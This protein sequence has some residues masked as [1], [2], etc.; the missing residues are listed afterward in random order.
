MSVHFF[1]LIVKVMH[2]HCRKKNLNLEKHIEE[3]KKLLIVLLP[4]ITITDIS[5]VFP[6]IQIFSIVKAIALH[7]S[8]YPDLFNSITCTFAIKINYRHF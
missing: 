3:G 2:I 6:H 1:P 5:N 7:M 8:L 4:V